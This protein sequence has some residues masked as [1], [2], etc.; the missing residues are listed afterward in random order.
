MWFIG[1]FTQ[2][3]C[4]VSRSLEKMLLIAVGLS[5]AVLV[6]IPILMYSINAMNSTSQLQMAETF[7]G[8]VHDYVD[9][10]DNGN[11]TGITTEINVPSSVTVSAIGDTLTV[12]Y[13]PEGQQ[14][15]SWSESYMHPIS[16]IAPN[17]A[18][19]Y[20]LQVQITEGNLVIVF[21]QIII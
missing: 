19:T 10:V 1:S 20:T 3:H 21:S 7:A 15:T 5:A 16:I 2:H 6:G 18:G 8:H 17:D 12:T 13:Q 14:A 11:S 4:M 9:I